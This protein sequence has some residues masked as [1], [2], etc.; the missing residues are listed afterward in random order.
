MTRIG[1]ILPS[2][3]KTLLNR[4][5]IAL[6]M[7]YLT[8]LIFLFFNLSAF[9]NLTFADFFVA[10]WFDLITM[11][12]FFLPY[13]GLYLL[14]LPIREYKLYKVF[15]KISFHLINTLLIALNLMDVEYFI[16]TSKRSTFDLFSMLSTGDDLSQLWMTFLRD[17]WILILFLIV[18]VTISEILYRKTQVTRPLSSNKRFSFYKVNIIS[19]ILIGPLFFIIGRGGFGLKPTGIIEASR[20][21]KTENTAFMLPT[22]FTMIKTIDQGSLE[23][24]KYLPLEKEQ[25]LFSPIHTSHPQQILPNGTN[26]VL[27]MLESFGT[28]FIGAFNDGKGYTPFF[29]S[30]IDQS[31]SFNYSFANGKKSIEAV[32]AIIASVPTLMENPYISSPYGDNKINT[33]PNILKK[34]GYESAFFHGATNG[35]MRFD[36]FAKICGYDH[37]FGRHEYDNDDHF[38]ET[39]GILDEY[40]NPW[41]ARKLTE[42]K[43]PFFSTLFTLSSHHPYFIPKHMKKKVKYGPQQ[44]C[45]SIS[46]GDIALRKFFE[47]AKKQPWYDNTLFVIVADHTPATKTPLYNQRSHMFRIPIVFYHPKGNVKPEKSDKIFQQLDILPTLLDM[48]N[49]ETKY[50]AFGNSFFDPTEGESI[51]YLGGSYYYFRDEH[52]TVFSGKKA[53]NLYNFTVKDV[54]LSDSISHYN[55]EVGLVENR[56]KAMIQRYNRDLILNQTIADEAKN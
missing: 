4:L 37:Y 2:H 36:G 26:V 47:E 25:Q 41:T 43:E 46:Y 6:L 30:I 32:P 55:M 17:F 7:L 35:S 20:Y 14:P 31:L 22:A 19:F 28:E 23:L 45:A 27:I 39:W 50:Y 12:L 11:G 29:D 1:E 38:D 18:L 49:I 8:R 44:I 24:K 40:F 15:F 9:Q 53:R 51:T 5:G 13:Y 56:I 21:Y 3:V 54:D 10:I 42:L 48:L 34:S 16:Y 33:L 52:M